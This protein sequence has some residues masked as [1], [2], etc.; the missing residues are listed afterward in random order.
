MYFRLLLLILSTAPSVICIEL[1]Q[2][3]LMVVKP[4]ESFS[5]GCKITGYSASGGGCTNWIRHSA[6]KAMEWIG[7]F[8]DSGN[9]GP[10]NTMKNKISFTAET[11]SN[12]VFLQEGEI[13]IILNH[14]LLISSTPAGSSCILWCFLC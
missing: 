7:W 1:N 5:I 13:H 6:G 4:G 12:T 2:P 9:T 3:A 14:D 11:S 8:C 10:S